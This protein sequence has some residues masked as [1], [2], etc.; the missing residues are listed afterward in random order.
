DEMRRLFEEN[1]KE[2]GWGDRELKIV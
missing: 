2:Y 1:K